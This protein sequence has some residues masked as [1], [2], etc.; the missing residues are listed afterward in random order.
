MSPKA[1]AVMGKWG[2][3]DYRPPFANYMH[4]N[5]PI[6]LNG[7]PTIKQ[8]ADDGLRSSLERQFAQMVDDALVRTIGDLENRQDSISN[9]IR[10][11]IKLFSVGIA[12]IITFPVF[13][14]AE[15]GLIS[16]STYNWIS[17]SFLTRAATFAVALVG[18][19][20]AVVTIA[21]GWD[22]VKAMSLP[23]LYKIMGGP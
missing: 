23:Y 7:I 13:L 10:N 18:F 17:N 8:Y 19:I 9:E 4:T 15:F 3:M 14:V 6:I 5:W 1:Q 20:S 21:V 11:P 16:I 12:F 22:Q 2:V